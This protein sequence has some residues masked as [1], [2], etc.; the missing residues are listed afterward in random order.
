MIIATENINI[1]F[2]IANISNNNIIDNYISNLLPNNLRHVNAIKCNTRY[3]IA[4]MILQSDMN[5]EEKEQI[6]NILLKDNKVVGYMGN[7]ITVNQLLE[8]INMNIVN[9]YLKEKL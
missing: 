3:Y 4:T 5:K 2:I 8:K 7:F 9:E 1:K 6:V